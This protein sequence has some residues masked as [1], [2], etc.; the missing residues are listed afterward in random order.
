LDLIQAIILGI[1]Q[2][3]TEFLPI[4]SSGHLVLVPWWLGWPRSPDLTFII[5][6]H[7]G[8]LCAVLVYF[9]REWVRV[10]KGG[11]ALLRG[12]S[13]ANP[14]SRLFIYLIIASIPAGIVGV[15]FAKPLGEIFQT[16]IIAAV[17]LLVTAALLV[18]SERKMS[19]TQET[20]TMEHMTWQDALVVGLAQ[21][22]AVL[23]GISRSGSTIA[24]GL[25]RDV[26]RADAARFSF[27]LSAPATVGAGLLALLELL[28]TGAFADQFPLLLVGFVGAAV[29]GYLSIA[30]LLTYL[31]RHRLYV[32]AA[33]CA[34]VGILSLLAIVLGR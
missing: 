24:A 2:G 26:N 4:S 29:V 32:F 15:P 11:L 16:P 6:V 12:P 21:L 8:T 20:H 7:L 27:L 5:A 1:V 25:Y 3:T 30:F 14:D 19:T 34:A 28:R 17:L 33:Y 31:Q 13:G 22:L 10:L 23:P 9:R 18:L